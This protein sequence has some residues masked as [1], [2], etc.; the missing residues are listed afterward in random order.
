MKNLSLFLGLVVLLLG[1]VFLGLGYGLFRTTPILEAEEP[2]G[3]C[4]NVVFYSSANDNDTINGTIGKTNFN[5]LCA[6]CHNRNMRDHLTGPALNGSMA[7]FKHDTS[8][9]I[10][11]VKNSE[12][13]VKNSGDVRIA[14]MHANYEAIKKPA[15]TLLTE[16]EVRSIILYIEAN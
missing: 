11:Y 6:S 3:F 7:R 14:E 1:V 15:F 13:Y 10:E 2:R 4:G 16:N 8:S 5:N 12:R 9:Y